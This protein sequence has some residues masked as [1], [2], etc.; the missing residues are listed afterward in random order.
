LQV[1]MRQSYCLLSAFFKYLVLVFR[2]E[3]CSAAAV[4]MRIHGWL[5]AAACRSTQCLGGGRER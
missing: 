3:S 1:W 5:H 4:L 2:C